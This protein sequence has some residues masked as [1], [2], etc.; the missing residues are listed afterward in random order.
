RVGA[1]FADAANA[2]RHPSQT[3]LGLRSR[4]QWTPDMALTLEVDNLADRLLADRA[5]FAQGDWRYFP[6]RERSAYLGVD[7]RSR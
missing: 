2:R 1:Y 3:V 4:W 6:A 5:D 7:W